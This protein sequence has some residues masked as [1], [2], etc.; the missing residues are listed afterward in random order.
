MGEKA[1]NKNGV[2]CKRLITKYRSEKTC[3]ELNRLIKDATRYVEKNENKGYSASSFLFEEHGTLLIN[4]LKEK[5]D[6]QSRLDKIRVS[7]IPVYRSLFEI[8]YN[9]K[10][11]EEKELLDRFMDLLDLELDK[12]NKTKAKN[13]KFI[14]L[15]NIKRFITNTDYSTKKE[16]FEAY[17]N[18]L[19]L[20]DINR[21]T[22][23]SYFDKNDLFERNKPSEKGNR[24]KMSHDEL[25]ENI[26]GQYVSTGGE[27]IEFSF[28]ARD[29]KFAI[30]KA[31]KKL[32][33]FLG[34]ISLFRHHFV[35]HYKYDIFDDVGSPIEEI[36]KLSFIVLR[37]EKISLEPHM[38]TYIKKL[39]IEKGMKK[40]LYLTDFVDLNVRNKLRFINHYTKIL[41]RIRRDPQKSELWNSLQEFLRLYYFACS[42]N[43]LTFSFLQFWTLAET[44]IKNIT[45]ELK[46]KKL[47]TI[48]K[49]ILKSRIKLA[50]NKNIHLEKRI[51]YL[52]FK[53]NQ[54]VHEGKLNEISEEDHVLA[55][56]IADSVL[57]FYLDNLLV[58]NNFDEYSF[59][60][61]N[62]NQDNKNLERYSELLNDLLEEKEYIK[63][64]KIINHIA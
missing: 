40:K 20:F 37:D 44:I 19:N 39:V 31:N 55:K 58:L 5:T 11:V 41:N 35:K 7:D 26:L 10:K 36:Q 16:E 60:L 54:I 17:K 45:G 51:S 56:Q 12:I 15:L 57:S 4:H 25:F 18:I 43:N 38:T 14:I 61:Q 24:R 33:S 62:M 52:Y 48:M 30:N 32:E 46:D 6:L 59:I 27:I 9:L 29:T 28:N 2:I 34:F 21:I 49:K 64:Y 8:F 53:R 23:E 3:N 42:E 22:Y 50:I 13:Y 1:L 47:R 63:I